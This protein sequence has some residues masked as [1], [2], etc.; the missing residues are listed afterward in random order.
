L[1]S[2][3]INLFRKAHLRPEYLQQVSSQNL[4]RYLY[5]LR[6][7]S[8]WTTS[9]AEAGSEEI[10]RHAKQVLTDGQLQNVMPLPC[11]LLTGETLI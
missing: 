10:W 6:F 1:T 8:G 7:T 11:L 9:S 4:K 3:L 5:L 2:D